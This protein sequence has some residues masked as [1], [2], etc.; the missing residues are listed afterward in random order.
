[1]RK[2]EEEKEKE[3]PT[4]GNISTPCEIPLLDPGRCGSAALIFFHSFSF[5]FLK[6]GIGRQAARAVHHRL[7]GRFEKSC[8]ERNERPHQRASATFFFFFLFNR[9][10]EALD[11]LHTLC[12]C[13]PDAYYRC[14]ITDSFSIH[15]A[16][17]R[18]IFSAFWVSSMA[19]A[20]GTRKVLS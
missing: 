13:A 8:C 18:C 2:E 1:M 10:T 5:L 19:T 17:P 3:L 9:M 15:S 16:P 7:C 6:R 11:E 12:E 14:F 20:A 4:C